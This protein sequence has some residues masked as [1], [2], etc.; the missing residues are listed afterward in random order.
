MANCPICRV[1]AFQKSQEP[2]E[3][4]V[5]LLRRISVMKATRS[6]REAREINLRRKMWTNALQRLRF[7]EATFFKDFLQK[8]QIFETKDMNTIS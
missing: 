7:D 8:W 5:T 1:G 3:F 2:N 6:H 4:A